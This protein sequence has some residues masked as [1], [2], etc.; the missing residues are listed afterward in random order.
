MVVTT[1]LA[2]ATKQAVGVEGSDKC[3][4]LREM[5]SEEYCRLGEICP[6][7]CQHK[8]FFFKYKGLN[9]GGLCESVCQQL[10]LF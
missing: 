1:T 2:D 9:T 6:S 8:A 10:E 4:H 7:L 5:N 3:F